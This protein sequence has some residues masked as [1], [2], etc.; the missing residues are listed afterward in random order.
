[1]C[2]RAISAA[3]NRSTVS[4]ACARDCDGAVTTATVTNAT[5]H[6]TLQMKLFSMLPRWDLMPERCYTKKTGSL[7]SC[8]ADTS[9]STAQESLPISETGPNMRPYLAIQVHDLNSSHSQT[10]LRRKSCSFCSLRHSHS[11]L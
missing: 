2:L 8:Q 7:N 10:C 1:M 11:P 4:R 6:E 9:D 3:T 5:R